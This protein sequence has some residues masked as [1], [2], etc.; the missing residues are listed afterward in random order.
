[1]AQTGMGYQTNES[2]VERIPIQKE[3]QAQTFSQP[4]TMSLDEARAAWGGNRL[5]LSFN[6]SGDN[7][8]G[9]A[10]NRP[11]S[12]DNLSGTGSNDKRSGSGGKPSGSAEG[13]PDSRLVSGFGRPL[14]VPGILC[15]PIVAQAGTIE[16]FVRV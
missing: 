2:N 4:W 1:M 9:S 8:P 14:T 15:E 7:R 13:V 6:R 12:N 3:P 5:A 10:D 11:G 16:T